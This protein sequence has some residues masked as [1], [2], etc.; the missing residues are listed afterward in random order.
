MDMVCQGVNFIFVYLDDNLVASQGSDE[1]RVHLTSLSDHLKAQVLV[2]NL[3]KCKF[4]QTS[5][6]FLGHLVSSGGFLPGRTTSK[7]FGISPS[8]PPSGK[9]W[10]LL[11]WS[12]FTAGLSW[13]QLSWCPS[14][15]ME[16][17]EPAVSRLRSPSMWS[18]LWPGSNRS[19][20]RGS[21]QGNEPQPLH[22]GAP[23]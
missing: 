1:H 8:P 4:A 6:S 12:T 10:N 22:S 14:F 11:V 16:S 20:Q 13:M 15:S 5:F 21:S 23:H 17:P 3:S 9:W 19:G 18:G 7:T 2:R